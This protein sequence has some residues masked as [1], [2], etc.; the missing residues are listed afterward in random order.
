[1]KQVIMALLISMSLSAF[2]QESKSVPAQ[3]QK[4]VVV[5]L[6]KDIKAKKENIKKEKKAIKADK[7][8]IRKHKKHSKKQA[9]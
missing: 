6:K 1:M 3:S 4:P 5:E 9:K 2:A 8:E 7:K